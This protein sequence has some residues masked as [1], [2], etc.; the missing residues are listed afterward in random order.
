[1][2]RAC[3]ANLDDDQEPQPCVLQQG[4]ASACPIAERLDRRGLT[5]AACEYWLPVQGPA[6]NPWISDDQAAQEAH[7]RLSV[8]C[9]A[10]WHS[11][12]QIHA[13]VERTAAQG[14]AESRVLTALAEGVELT[15]DDI[16][17]ECDMGREAA[18]S[19]L[20]ALID[21]GLVETMLE[22]PYR[23]KTYRRS[24]ASAQ[25]DAPTETYGR[26]RPKSG[27]RLGG[28]LEA[29]EAQPGA[30]RADEIMRRT[31]LPF[32]RAQNFI[33]VLIGMGWIRR[34]SLLGRGRPGIYEVVR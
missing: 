24:S 7:A 21:R 14:D 25:P 1:V 22:G 23:R 11:P 17:D 34:L 2:T 18:R 3:H 12:L 10:R 8:M 29:A 26:E 33:G 31:G 6:S 16:R 13:E 28:V 30:F 5:Q 27:T 9:S 19:T 32:E 4:N 15:L 20:S